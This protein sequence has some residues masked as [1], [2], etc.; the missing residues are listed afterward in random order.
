MTTPMHLS[1]VIRSTMTGQR[2][3]SQT[4]R[5][6]ERMGRTTK[7]LTGYLAVMA[8]YAALSFLK[9]GIDNLVAFELEM[10][11]LNAI[12]QMQS[13]EF[14]NLRSSIKQTADVYKFGYKEMTTAAY[15][16][17]SAGYTQTDSLEAVLAVSS[18]LALSG[19]GG[20]VETTKAVTGTMNAFGYGVEGTEEVV[21]VLSET[22]RRG[23]IVMDDISLSIGKVAPAAAAANQS[24]HTMGT[25][26]AFLTSEGMGPQIAATSIARVFETL[27][28]PGSLEKMR[29]FGIAYSSLTGADIKSS[30]TLKTLV[31]S[32]NDYEMQINS[33]TMNLEKYALVT[34][35]INGDLVDLNVVIEG[36]EN[37]ITA[38]GDEY[39][40]INNII[41]AFSD[42]ISKV[43]IEE[44]TNRIKVM[45]IRLTAEK[46]GRKLNSMELDQIK[47]LEMANK[48]YSLQVEEMS[49]EINKQRISERNI[50]REMKKEESELTKL[51]KTKSKYEAK[52]GDIDDE[53]KKLIDSEE[54][55]QDLISDGNLQ[56]AEYIATLGEFLPFEEILGNINEQFKGMSDIQKSLAVAE[57]F[58]SKRALRGVNTMLS[59]MEK[60]NGFFDNFNSISG[61]SG[62]AAEAFANF[63]TEITDET[64]YWRQE[65]E[66]VRMELAEKIWPLVQSVFIVLEPLLALLGKAPE[67]GGILAAIY[68]VTLAMKG[69]G[70]Q[71]AQTAVAVAAATGGAP[72]AAS[73]ATGLGGIGFAAAKIGMVAGGA[74]AAYGGV[75]LAQYG[76]KE[77]NK[78]AELGGWM[79]TG[80]GVG[81]TLGALL[82]SPLGPA[83]NILGAAGGALIGGAIGGIGYG[84]YELGKALGWWGGDDE[85]KGGGATIGGVWKSNKT[86][87]Q[88]Y[89]AA[90]PEERGLDDFIIR[91]GMPP[92]R[93]NKGDV[94]MG[95]TNL[96]NES[97]G[98]SQI[99]IENISI[100]VGDSATGQ[101]ILDEIQNSIDVKRRMYGD[102]EELVDVR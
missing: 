90:H 57:I 83:G 34:G 25:M 97:S 18:K 23:R 10:S 93:F 73:M 54:E 12:M 59:D 78:L 58:P 19:Y 56:M 5:S 22:I 32:L 74:V 68:L 70:L 95:G 66:K 1:I 76:K 6:M 61:E 8:T 86:L 13:D 47:Q 60:L 55:Y 53:V 79:A 71:S 65:W 14:E 17:A 36:Q 16:A 87:R 69:L 102:N 94:I 37:K 35:N 92:L 72:A 49:L 29:E 40:R 75:K 15:H 64:R 42:K 101:D 50:T 91:P 20:L 11:R 77:D 33:I 80:A 26:W 84:G 4:N 96:L 88:D 100:I 98:G 9:T 27:L 7:M 52:L 89:Y 62:E 46:Q 39:N 2:A 44:Q 99:T 31:N 67:I 3:F 43:S 28:S 82:G 48:D 21:N 38:L 45:K 41:T 51:N 30:D 85:D 24:L 81:F 63:L